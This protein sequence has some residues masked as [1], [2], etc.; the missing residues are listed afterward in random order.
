[1]PAGDLLTYPG[2]V[3]WAGLLLSVVGP[4][5][6]GYWL[7]STTDRS[8]WHPTWSASDEPTEAGVAPGKALRDGMYPAL[9]G[10]AV[11]T[12]DLLN[13]L[14]DE[15]DPSGGSGTLAWWDPAR[16]RRFTATAFP[17]RAEP[18]TAEGVQHLSH[19]LV[20]LMWVVGRSGLIVDLD[21]GS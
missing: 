4:D 15:M 8:G 16:D 21:E 18:S 3:E 17:R 13:A 11:E 6:S 12:A 7:T 14:L 20:D 19:S 1:M 5:V 2:D 9:I 10:V